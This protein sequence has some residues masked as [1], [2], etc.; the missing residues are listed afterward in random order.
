MYQI[1]HCLTLDGVDVFGTWVDNLKDRKAA[2]RIVARV[3]RVKAGNFGDC[4]PVGHGVWELRIDCGAGY[5]LY[6]AIVGRRAVLLL[7]G[8]DKRKQAQDIRHA[9]SLWIGYQQRGAKP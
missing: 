3:E 9:I 8:G 5:R 2:G 4:K 7:C 6:Y 1:L